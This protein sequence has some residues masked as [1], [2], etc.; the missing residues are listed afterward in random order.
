MYPQRPEG[1]WSVMTLVHAVS[2]SL[3][4]LLPKWPI[5]IVKTTCFGSDYELIPHNIGFNVM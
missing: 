1:G 2:S 4:N 3:L 5:D